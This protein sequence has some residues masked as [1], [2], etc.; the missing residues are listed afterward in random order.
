[1]AI[2]KAMRHPQKR[3]EGGEKHVFNFAWSYLDVVQEMKVFCIR[4]KIILNL[5]MFDE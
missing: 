4:Y 2:K 1:M 5:F 3:E